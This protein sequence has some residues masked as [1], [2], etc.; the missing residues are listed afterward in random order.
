[1]GPDRRYDSFG[2]SFGPNRRFSTH[3]GPN[4]MF[5][6]RTR[7]LVNQD[8][9]W[10]EAWA[11]LGLRPTLDDL[12]LRLG[13]ILDQP[14]ANFWTRL[15]LRRRESVV[16]TEQMSSVETGQMSSVE[17]RQMSAVETGQMSAAG[18]DVCC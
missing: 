2:L 7:T 8:W 9:T 15:G 4:L 17:T 16:E 13:P 1:M 6:D 3:F 12:G 11:D 18:T 14:W 5:L 10:A